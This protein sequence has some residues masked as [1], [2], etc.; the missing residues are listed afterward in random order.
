MW[1]EA[2]EG[3]GASF[4]FALAKIKVASELVGF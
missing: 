4:I 3:C 2:R 1:V